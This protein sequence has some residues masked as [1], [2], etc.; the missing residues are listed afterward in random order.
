MRKP[1][2]R[3]FIALRHYAL[4]YAELAQ[5]VTELEAQTGKDISDIHEVLRWLGQENQSRADE[6]AALS[7]PV[8]DW[9]TRRFIG[10]LKDGQ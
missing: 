4:T 10:F 9:E 2:K 7:S 1:S 8:S 3:A 5:K 6:I